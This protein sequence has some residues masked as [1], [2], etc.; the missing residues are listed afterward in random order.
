MTLD[1]CA[2]LA[3]EACEGYMFHSLTSKEIDGRNLELGSPRFSGNDL[4][5]LSFDYF[6]CKTS[7]FLLVNCCFRLWLSIAV[8]CVTAT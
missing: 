8:L 5:A 4:N 2:T 3:Q 7:R 6:W 1:A